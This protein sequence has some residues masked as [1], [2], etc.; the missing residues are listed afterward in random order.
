MES[1]AAG[2]GFVLLAADKRYLN[3][4]QIYINDYLENDRLLHIKSNYQIFPV[5]SRGIDFVG[6]VTRHGYCLARKRNKK[7][8]CRTVAA[9]R[10][11]G[12]VSKEI[13]LMLASRLGFMYHCN[14]VNLLRK[15][16]M[17]DGKEV[18]KRVMVG[19]QAQNIP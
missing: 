9:L 10:K 11:K 4:V 5:E 3:G 6:Y 14:S 17:K 13:R 15:L 12:H 16:D 7:A 1:S 18:D 8:L 2:F 19:L